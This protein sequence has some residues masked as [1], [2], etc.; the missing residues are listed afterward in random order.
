MW[1]WWAPWLTCATR[2]YWVTLPDYRPDGRG[3]ITASVIRGGLK[4]GRDSSLIALERKRNFFF[5]IFGLHINVCTESNYRGRGGKPGALQTTIR[6]PA[7]RNLPK[8]CECRAAHPSL[9]PLLINLQCKPPR[10]FNIRFTYPFAPNFLL[11]S[12]IKLEYKNEY[13]IAGEINVE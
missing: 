6:L 13:D 7:S 4:M 8:R 10:T 5:L 12:L 3:I 1:R 9:S 11:P 2:T